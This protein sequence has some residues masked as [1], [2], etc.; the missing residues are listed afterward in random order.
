[1]NAVEVIPYDP[2]PK[3]GTRLAHRRERALENGGVVEICRFTER[4]KKG[5]LGVKLTYL[6]PIE[7]G[8]R[9]RLVFM[10]SDEAAAMTQ[11]MLSEFFGIGICA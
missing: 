7:D 11:I 10:L 4:N 1:M 8:K 2:E 9:T 5:E 6:S 3:P